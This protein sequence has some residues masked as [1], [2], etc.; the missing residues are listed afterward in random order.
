[1]IPFVSISVNFSV[2]TV[3]DNDGA[4]PVDALRAA[5]VVPAGP[6]PVKRLFRNPV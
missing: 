1:L 4:I 2:G 3:D 5:L 6:L